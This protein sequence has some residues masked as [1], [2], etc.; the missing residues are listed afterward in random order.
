MVWE[1][2][3][4]YFGLGK[5]GIYTWW[6]QMWVKILQVDGGLVSLFSLFFTLK[7]Y[8]N[9]W[10][11]TENMVNLFFS[12][13]FQFYFSMIFYSYEGQVEEEAYEEIETKASKDEAEVL[14]GWVR[15][16]S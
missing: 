10:I 13:N 4:A 7:F 1:I 11:Q 5:T 8:V 3:F 16:E 15:L 14:V 2:K 9:N 6:I 12:F